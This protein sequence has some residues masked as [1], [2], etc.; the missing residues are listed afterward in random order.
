VLL[1][2]VSGFLEWVPDVIEHRTH[3]GAEYYSIGLAL[4]DGRG[5]SDPFSEITGPTA[6][7]PPLYPALL[8]ALISIFGDKQHV[9]SVIVILMN[10]TV[11]LV[12]VTLYCLMTR[13]RQQLNPGVGLAFFMLWIGVFH[14][15]FLVLTSDVWVLM[16]VS[17]I[18]VIA[19][20]N[21]IE[22]RVV[23]PVRWGL[24]GGLAAVTSPT[25]VIGW[26]SVVGLSFLRRPGER[27]KWLVAAA[28]AL[29]CA[30]PWALR[31]ALVFH[32][33]IPVKSNAA[34]E[35]Y[36]G[37][38]VDQDGIYSLQSMMQHPFNDAALRFEYTK[39]GEIEF[40]RMHGERF[41]NLLQADP[42]PFFRRVG[43]RLL[44]AT[45]HYVPL[46]DTENGPTQT[47]LKRIVYP[48]PFLL[49]AIAV[50][51]RGG[52]QQALLVLGA[53]VGVYLAGYVV[54][55]FYIRYL[56]PMTPALC[57]TAYLSLDQLLLAWARR[58]QA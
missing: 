22:R 34:F 30:A 44:A 36:Q 5:F 31:N 21:Y 46:S 11:V 19:T 49:F 13:A 48:L 18:M 32:K 2:I 56:L 7:M 9:A 47:W 3:L 39:L 4:S 54:A 20:F 25:L 38:Y 50:W 37:S 8:A 10:V 14:Y 27:K 6:W 52:H 43:N 51:V 57:L 41:L 33:F 17:N 15:W 55:A 28:I 26:G 16:L 53:L 12:G 29:A 35:F 1:A 40:V 42:K 23:R 45:V 58:K 24:L